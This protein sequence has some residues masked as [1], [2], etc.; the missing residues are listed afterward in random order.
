MV[1]SQAVQDLL[2]PSVI[3]VLDIRPGIHVKVQI[4]DA[5]PIPVVHG[6]FGEVN[7]G[8]K[9]AEPVLVYEQLLV[10]QKSLEGPVN[11]WVLPVFHETGSH[12]AAVSDDPF[13]TYPRPGTVGPPKWV[14]PLY[15]AESST[16]AT[17]LFLLSCSHKGNSERTDQVEV[18]TKLQ[19]SLTVSVHS[20]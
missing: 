7:G 13:I 9:Q 4:P 20:S 12:D 17:F 5:L 6:G 16:K 2:A 19:H 11:V 3:V 18:S 8:P 14:G 15:F 10:S 1:I